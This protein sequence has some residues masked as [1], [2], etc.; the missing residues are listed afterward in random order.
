MRW[1][2]LINELDDRSKLHA[3][4]FFRQ[5]RFIVAVSSTSLL[6][7][8]GR[9]VLFLWMMKTMFRLSAGMVAAAGLILKQ[10]PRPA[11]F[12]WGDHVLGM[13]MLML[14]CSTILQLYQPN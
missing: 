14:I 1:R 2:K 5:V 12:S 10:K 7:D 13:L 4:I 9:P 11:S 8:K 6:I 3:A